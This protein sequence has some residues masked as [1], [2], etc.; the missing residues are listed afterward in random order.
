[1][2][3]FP[4][5]VGVDWAD[6]KHDICLFDQTKNTMEFDVIA[7]APEAISDWV[8]SMQQRFPDTQIIICIEQ[9]RGPLIYHLMR[10]DFISLVPINPK[11]LAR[12]REAVGSNAG[13]KDDPSDAQLLAELVAKHGDRFHI[14]KPDTEETRL[15]KLLVEDR[16]KLVNQRVA[17]T[18]ELKSLLKEYFPLVLSLCSKLYS[19]VACGLLTRWAS[20]A[21]LKT[22]LFEDIRELYRSHGRASQQQLRERWLLIQKAQPL[23]TDGAVITSHKMLVGVIVL[24]IQQ[25]NKAIKEYDA[26]I[27][28]L[29]AQHPNYEV[30]NSFPGAG[31]AMGPRTLCAFG[32]DRER[33]ASARD[34]QAFCGV[35]PVTK[36]SGKSVIVQRRWACNKFLL[37][38]FHEYACMSIKFSDWARAYYDIMKEK[39]GRHHAA[40]RALAFKWIRIMFSCWKTD[41]L[42]DETKYIECL[43]RRNSPIIKRLELNALAKA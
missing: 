35:A 28:K 6:E 10:Y 36:R 29:Y 11:Q 34:L 33:F 25:L 9:S 27:E 23:T 7:Q 3:A 5:V 8:C 38:T 39:T 30:F 24:Q 42:Y 26:A 21:E 2:Q 17:Y 13:A 15:L 32:T 16:R 4:V 1:M 40:L 22:A 12:F 14:W 41:S 18:N 19:A 20:L 31:A 43:K 37:Q